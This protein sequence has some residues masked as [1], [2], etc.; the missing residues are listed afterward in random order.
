MASMCCKGKIMVTKCQEVVDA[1]EFTNL[2]HLPDPKH[3]R[4][5]VWGERGGGRQHLLDRV[6]FLFASHLHHLFK[7]VV[8]IVGI[9][10]VS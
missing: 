9:E 4:G 8:R 1:V 6:P 2:E 3:L 5:K 7:E 10:A